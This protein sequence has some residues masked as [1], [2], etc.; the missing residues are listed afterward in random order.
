MHPVTAPVIGFA[1]L[2]FAFLVRRYSAV[3]RVTNHSVGA[4]IIRPIST[5]ETP[6]LGLHNSH[7]FHYSFPAS[8]FT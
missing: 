7:T 6:A 5:P 1:V 3:L 8:E 2:R 4:D